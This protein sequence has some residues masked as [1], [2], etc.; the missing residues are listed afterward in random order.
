MVTVKRVRYL[1][2]DGC[3]KLEGAWFALNQIIRKGRRGARPVVF[4]GNVVD[5]CAP[6]P[7]S[8]TDRRGVAQAKIEACAGRDQW[9]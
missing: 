6:D 3:R 2:L 8:A 5:A 9:Q 1:K 4:V 7:I